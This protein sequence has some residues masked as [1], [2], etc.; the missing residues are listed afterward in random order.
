M[1][2]NKT[3][4]KQYGCINK[5]ECFLLGELLEYLQVDRLVSKSVRILKAIFRYTPLEGQ[6]STLKTSFAFIS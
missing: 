4:L 2:T 3:I 6:L 5:S 1:L